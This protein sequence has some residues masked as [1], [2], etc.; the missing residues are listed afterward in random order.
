MPGVNSVDRVHRIEVA[1]VDVEALRAEDA[2]REREEPVLRPRFAE[3][4][5][6]SWTPDS[7]G[8]WETLD[9]GSRL[10]RLRIGAPGALSLNLGLDTFDLP[11]GASFWVH[12]ADG[13]NVQ[14]P[15]TAAHR[16]A[17]G[18]L[19]TAVVPG[20]ELVA[21]LHLPA[22]AEG[23]LEI[24]S[25]N[26]GYRFFAELEAQP[27]A[28]RGSCNVN[29]VCPEGDPWRAQIRSVARITISGIWLCSGQLVNTTAADETPYLLT[30][31]HCIEEESEAPSVVA[32][33]NHQSPACSDL[34]G[35][36]LDQNQSG[37]T[38]VASDVFDSGSDFTLVELDQ[39]P[40]TEFNVYYAGWDA[41]DQ[42]PDSTLTI[43]HP[44]GDEKSI[45]FDDDPPTVSSYL[46]DTSPGNGRYWRIGD[47]DLGTTEGG[48]SGA[49]LFDAATGRCIGTLSGGLAACENDDPDWYGRLFSQ[50]TGGGTPDSRL[51]DWLDP[52]GIGTMFVDGKNAS[53]SMGDEETWLVPAVA[54][55]AGEGSSNWKSQIAV[56]NPGSEPRAVSLYFVADGQPWPGTLLSGPHIVNPNASLYI[57]D[58]LLSQNPTSGL[59]YATVDG[60]GTAVFVRT[61]NLA[62]GGVTFGQGQPGILLNSTSTAR[63]L[64]L[65]LVHSEPGVFRTNVGLAQTSS[66]SYR[67]RFEI[68]SAAGALLAQREYSQSVAWRQINDIFGKFGIGNQVV[69]GGWIRATLVGGSPAFWT[70][71]A[72]VIDAATDDPTYIL[73]VAP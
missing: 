31:Q 53:G 47:W 46:G 63:E 67:V 58:P 1:R 4:V 45:S 20:D 39:Q 30:A 14:G 68:Y 15:Y 50:W 49:C 54:S 62:A 26:R 38:W 42:I 3:P 66:G 8:S 44:N 29:V 17:S 2:R 10:W 64:V 21:E 33:W 41:R 25:V 16:N 73:P 40:S 61:Y 28:K 23:R 48:S 27:N 18:G 37:A 9:D 22:G 11:A 36:S 65:P 43:H 34:A 19:A 60:W 51:S 71:Y 32:Y 6:G 35:G 52:Q 24:S 5:T 57:D 7:S 59:I 56:A 72:T 13:A 55:L 12:D 70:T 69:E